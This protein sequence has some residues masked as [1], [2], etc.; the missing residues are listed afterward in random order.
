MA[1]TPVFWYIE[2]QLESEIANV[3]TQ[4]ADGEEAADR[5]RAATDPLRDGKFI[6]VHADAFY[7]ALDEYLADAKRINGE[8]RSLA[9]RLERAA[10]DTNSTMQAIS[11]IIKS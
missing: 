3:K 9:Q 11:A 2:E 5:I 10:A 1:S 6:G 7:R 8:I 4:A